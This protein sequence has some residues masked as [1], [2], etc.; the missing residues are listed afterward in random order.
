MVTPL[1]VI[2]CAIFPLH[3]EGG[4]EDSKYVSRWVVTLNSVDVLEP[5]YELKSGAP[6]EM[7]EG[8]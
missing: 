7:V 3:R 8:V 6:G 1:T 5:D 4:V 2:C